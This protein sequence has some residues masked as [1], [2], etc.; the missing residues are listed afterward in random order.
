MNMKVMV[1]SALNRIPF[2]FQ[3]RLP[4]WSPKNLAAC[5]LSSFA[6]IIGIA[7]SPA[8]SPP[9]APA[10]LP[11]PT[12]L[13]ADADSKSI[14]AKPGEVSVNFTFT[15]SNLA[16]VPITITAV[17]ASC[18]CTAAKVPP[19]P[20]ILPPGTNGTIEVAMNL[21]GKMGTFAKTVT[22]MSSAGDKTL[23][24]SVT[25][26]PAA[27]PPAVSPS[28]PL[29]A[30]AVRG[31][32]VP[33]GVNLPAPTTNAERERNLLLAKA[34]RQAVF[35]GECAKCHAE[36]ALGKSGREL[37]VAVC[38]ICHDDGHRASVVPDLQALKFKPNAQYW[39]TWITFG[40]AT[41]MMPGFAQA[42]GGPL[43]AAQINSLVVY[44]GKDFL[45]AAVPAP[46]APPV[47]VPSAVNP[48]PSQPIP[49]GQ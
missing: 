37:Y 44:L 23:T 42:E 13:V 22:V 30:A 43:T 39:R 28:P 11:A 8:Q 33:P 4:M 14:T 21:L 12:Q 16:A 40:K 9:P 18:G 24:V 46:S 6:L 19:L 27:L 47:T 5:L 15:L 17:R 38:G 7:A 2:V 10:S 35:K 48:P 49:V 32:A 3:P 34:D 29:H 41:T 26:P 20:W 45:T 31:V 1:P 25:M 36:P